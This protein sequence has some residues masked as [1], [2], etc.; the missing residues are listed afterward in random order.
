MTSKRSKHELKR[1]VEN[2]IRAVLQLDWDPIGLD[3]AVGD[4]YDSYI[5]SI[6]SL[7]H[8]GASEA[9]VAQHLRSIETERM[10]LPGA[11]LE[12]LRLVGA[13]LRALELW[14]LKPPR[15]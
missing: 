13:K 2:R 4:E 5:G 12:Q 1:L 14:G 6:Y 11:S 10:G 9:E 8:K 3:D 15:P 7:L